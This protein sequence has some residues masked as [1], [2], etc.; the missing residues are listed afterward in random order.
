MIKMFII[1]WVWASGSFFGQVP[2]IESSSNNFP[3]PKINLKFEEY[4]ND[5]GRQLLKKAEIG[6]KA[7]KTIGLKMDFLAEKIENEIGQ[8]V[9]IDRI[10]EGV[11][12]SFDRQVLFQN[13]NITMIESNKDELWRLG[14]IIQEIPNSNLLILGHTNNTGSK[15]Y[16]R[17]LSKKRAIAVAN[18]LIS[19]GLD[20]KNIKIKGKGES[21]PLVSDS[22]NLGHL[23]NQRIEIVIYAGRKMKADSD[24]KEF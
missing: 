22:E 11:L 4:K 9:N 2:V 3:K 12:L 13:D 5:T 8:M 1:L 15:K 17:K 6:G 20:R 7:G 18:E 19:A 14:N 24:N 21:E 16:N 10:Y 23:T